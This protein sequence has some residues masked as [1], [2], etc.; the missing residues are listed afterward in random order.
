MKGDNDIMILPADKGKT[1]VIMDSSN[2]KQ[3]LKAILNNT[4]VYEV[5]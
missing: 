2:Y 5:L 3:K 4:T 1:T